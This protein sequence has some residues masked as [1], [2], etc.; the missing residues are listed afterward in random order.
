MCQIIYARTAIPP[1]ETLQEFFEQNHDGAGM[2]W[3]MDGRVEFSKGFFDFSEFLAAFKEIPFPKVAHMRYE[4]HGGVSAELCH[5]FPVTPSSGLALRGSPTWVLFHNG[6][7][8]KFDDDLKMAILSGKLRI[9]RGPMSDSRAMA[10]LAGKFGLGVLDYLDFGTDRVLLMSGEKIR[11]YGFWH[12][13]E[14]WAESAFS[15][16]NLGI[17]KGIDRDSRG[18]VVYDGSRRD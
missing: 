13:K 12:E 5:P 18:G 11:R 3:Q 15:A 14:G 16:R 2:A 6:V 9:P 7:Y 4:T 1:D 10:I 8:H 17:W